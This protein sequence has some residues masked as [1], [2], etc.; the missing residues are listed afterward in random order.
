MKKRSIWIGVVL[1]LLVLGAAAGWLYSNWYWGN[2]VQLGEQV[3]EKS[4]TQLDLTGL[5]LPQTEVLREFTQLQQLDVRDHELTAAE[6]EQLCL[7]LPDCSILWKVPFQGEYLE[8]S[9]QELTVSQLSESDLEMLRFF[10]QLREIDA[11]GCYDYALLETLKAQRPDLQICYTVQLGGVDYPQIVTELTLVDPDV[12]ELAA[13][14]PYLPELKNVYLTGTLPENDVIYGLQTLRQDVVF[15]WDFTLFGV[16]TSSTATELI[17]NDIPMESTEQ[18][19]NAL[20]YFYNLERVEMC[21]CGIPSEQMDALW[22]RHP[23]TRF[24]WSI[25]IRDGVVRTDI[26]ALIPYKLGYDIDHPLYD[27]DCLE[28]KYCVDLVCLDMGH[29]K[30]TDVS[31]LYN[32]PKMQYLVLVDMPC[33]D[34]SALATLK[35]LIYLELFNV[36]F[37]QTEVLSG[38]TKLQDLNIGFTPKPKLDVLKQMT[39]LKRLWMPATKLNDE[40]FTDLVEHLP[41]TKV[42]MYVRRPTDAN[43]RDNDNYRAMRDLLGMHYMK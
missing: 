42:V 18:I 26:N 28:L 37:T 41:D 2:H 8:E 9:L 1:A 38:L 29:M 33:A 12:S 24:V 25:K 40:E 31:F 27:E 10:P 20:K 32:M 15:H 21:N 14:L 16:I 11:T 36:P 30:I 34:F 3:Y 13:A 4:I 5:E 39:W 35:D 7:A 6:Y 22:K 43:W 19:E 17:L 23:E